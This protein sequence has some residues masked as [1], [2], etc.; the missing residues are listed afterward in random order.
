MTTTNITQARTNLF[1]LAE[2][3][4]N[5]NDTINVTTKD[6]SFVMMSEEDYNGL[7]ETLYLYSIPG[8]QKSIQEGIDTPLED[9]AELDWENELK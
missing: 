4:V 7:M 3:V 1:K 8:M 9:C 2:R 5:Y 6:G